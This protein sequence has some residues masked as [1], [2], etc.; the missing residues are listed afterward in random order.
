[1]VDLS[2]LKF[3]GVQGESTRGG[4]ELGKPQPIGGESTRIDRL[5][6]LQGIQGEA[7]AAGYA[8]WIP[9]L[10]FAQAVPRRGGGGQRG[11]S[12]DLRCEALSG[13][14]SS[15]VY[16]AYAAGQRFPSVTLV[17]LRN[18]TKSMSVNMTG[19]FITSINRQPGSG[20]AA[21]EA[22]DLNFETI[23]ISN[24]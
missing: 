11:D 9:I 20:G 21:V 16:H 22:F 3:Q 19:V 4:P 24:Y 10:S 17:V 12:A 14:H 6:R 18:G 23:A 5:V 1:M 15:R 2:M 8:G 7:R 13:S